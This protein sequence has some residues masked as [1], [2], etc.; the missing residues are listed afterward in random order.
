MG[1]GQEVL[2][3][4]RAVNEAELSLAVVAQRSK[5]TMTLRPVTIKQILESVQPHPW[6]LVG[7]K[8]QQLYASS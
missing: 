3:R 5:D 1:L 6:V 7:D 2:T 8:P 4:S